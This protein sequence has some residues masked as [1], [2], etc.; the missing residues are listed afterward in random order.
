MFHSPL[1][2]LILV[3]LALLALPAV[4][5]LCA[6]AFDLPVLGVG[7]AA[8]SAAAI[9]VMR[10]HVGISLVDATLAVT[11]LAAAAILVASIAGAYRWLL[12]RPRPI[13][14]PVAR[15]IRD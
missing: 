14:L 10:P 2:I 4:W 1:A 8:A 13:P 6:V 11:A 12:G 7:I 15:L 9:Y 3:V 5:M